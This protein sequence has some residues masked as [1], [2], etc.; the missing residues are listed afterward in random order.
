MNERFKQVLEIIRTILI[1]VI[2][3]VVFRMVI[4]QPFYVIGSSMAPNFH[5]SDYLFIDE[6]SY[7]LRAPKR[8]EVIVFS[9]PESSCTEFVE[10]HP[11]SKNILPNSPC[12]N[13]IKRVIGLP[14]ETIEVKNGLVRIYNSEN[15][16][17]LTLDENYVEPGVKTLGN[18]KVTIGKNE[19]YV[20]GDNRLP[21]ASSDSREWGVLEKKFIIGRAWVRLLP[22]QDMGFI[23]KAKY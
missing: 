15:P 2:S 13:Y 5:E 8:G 3:V 22:P 20:L 17:G 12:R 9:H 23:G 16:N 19:F 11:V 14:G 21:N 7:F 4:L 1:V 6:L 10:K 18:Q